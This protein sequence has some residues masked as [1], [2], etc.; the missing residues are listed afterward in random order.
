ME[1]LINSLYK[2]SNIPDKF[3]ECMKNYF[4]KDI[5]EDLI[6]EELIS[7]ENIHLKEKKIYS[8][9][10][11]LKKFFE[12]NE[13]FNEYYYKRSNYYMPKDKKIEAAKYLI[14][15][16]PKKSSNDNY[17]FQEKQRKLFNLY[18]IFTN[19]H[20]ETIEIERNDKNEGIWEYS[21]T[22]IYEIKND[23]KSDER[24][25]TKLKDISKLLGYDVRKDLVHEDI[26]NIC[27]NEILYH[28]ICMKIDHDIYMKI[29]K[30]LKEKY[31]NPINH[32]ENFKSGARDL[33]EEYFDEIG[34]DKAKTYFPN[35]FSEKDR[36]TLNIIFDR[37]TRKNI[38]EVEKKYNGIMQKILKNPKLAEKIKNGELSDRNYNS[39]P[40][41]VYN[42]GDD[43]D[44]SDENPINK[45]TEIS[46]EA[47]IYELLLD[48]GKFKS[49][50]WMMQSKS[51]D[52]ED[53]EYKGKKYK[54]NPDDG[55]HY[56]IVC[57][58]NNDCKIYIEVK[59]T[60]YEYAHGDK[61]PMF[62]SQKQIDTMEKT[63]SPNEYI[64]AVVFNVMENPQHFFLTMNKNIY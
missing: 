28:D 53:F 4:G 54:I 14:S 32:N 56:D 50:T 59:S 30:L 26:G 47:Y 44:F 60:R 17:D 61:V 39:E 6:D 9:N 35:T 62:L 18:Q 36:I 49:V 58:T 63:N 1:T 8:Y 45:K 51:G 24:I 20:Y 41:M 2:D 3:K 55:S 13:D 48:S 64:L 27:S 11:D 15:I 21:N 23:G 43:F 22:Y 29:D 57:E 42:Y 52:G 40:V 16:I 38:T 5:N 34:E 7:I 33:I 46:G 19:G 10:N 31:D 12:M 37:E 25:P